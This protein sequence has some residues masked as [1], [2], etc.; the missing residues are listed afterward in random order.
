MPPQ[1]LLQALRR[2][3]FLPFRLHVSDGT[4]HDVRHPELLLVA[5]G[6][7]VV[8]MPSAS[9]PFPQVERYEIVDLAHVVGLEPLQTPAAQGDGS[10]GGS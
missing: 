1:D 5:P 3:P 7:A 4:V 2:R 9:L 6:S 8:G 10:G